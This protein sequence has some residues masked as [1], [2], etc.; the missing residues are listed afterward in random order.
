MIYYIYNYKTKELFSFSVY[1]QRFDF[2]K[3]L[4]IHERINLGIIDLL[5]SSKFVHLLNN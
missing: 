3:K 5:K 4:S 1:Y 2:I